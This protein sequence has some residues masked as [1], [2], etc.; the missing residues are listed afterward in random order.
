MPEVL[1]ETAQCSCHKFIHLHDGN[2]GVHGFVTKQEPS[3]PAWE[4]CPSCAGDLDTGYECTKCGRD[5][6]SY[7]HD[8]VLRI[9]AEGEQ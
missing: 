9:E 3:Q 6:Q 4:Y 5:W 2:C 8:A 7:V 1:T